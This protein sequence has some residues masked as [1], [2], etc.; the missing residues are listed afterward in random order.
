VAVAARRL[1]REALGA[2][3]GVDP[4]ERSGEAAIA[5][6][7]RLGFVAQTPGGGLRTTDKQA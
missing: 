3:A 2:P 6:L 7:V 4:L 1:A 5:T